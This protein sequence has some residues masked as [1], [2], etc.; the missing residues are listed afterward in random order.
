MK[1]AWSGARP[2]SGLIWSAIFLSLA[3]VFLPKPLNAQRLAQSLD[4]NW[5]SV[6]HY[7]DLMCDLLLVRRLPPW[8]SN[9]GKRLVK[10]PKIYVRDSGLLHVL[11]GLNSLDAVLGHPVAGA[12]WEGFV[13]EALLAEARDNARAFFYRTHAGAEIDLVLE[14]A[15]GRRWAIEIKKSTAPTIG[16]GFT[17]A[18]DDIKAERRI[19]VHKGEHVFR[20]VAVLRPC[21]CW[22]RSRRYRQKV[23]REVRSRQAHRQTPSRKIV[24][25]YTLRKNALT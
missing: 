2:S 9:E 15:P 16:K 10:S 24:W 18:A 25:K 3:F 7:L 5:H 11:L 20:C 8:A 14:I 12:S 21:L 6:T 23:E 17:V 1:Q 22:K 13:I 19:V 4:A